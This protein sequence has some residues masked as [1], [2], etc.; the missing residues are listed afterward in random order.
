MLKVKT[1]ARWRYFRPRTRGRLSDITAYEPESIYAE[2]RL[3]AQEFY[4]RARPRIGRTRNV[5]RTTGEAV[6]ML[7]AHQPSDPKHLLAL[8]IL[9]SPNAA[10]AQ[11]DLDEHHGGYRNREA[12]VFEL[13]DFNDTFVSTVLALSPE[14]RRDF[15]G[16]AKDELDYFCEQ[17]HIKN[18]SDQQYEAIWHG[19]SREIAVFLAAKEIG[20]IVHMSSRVQDSMGIDMTITDAEAKRAINIDVKTHSAYHF[21]LLELYEQQRISEEKRLQCELSG[22][23]ESKNGHGDQAVTTVLFRI[24]TDRLGEID[25]FAFKDIGPVA[26]LIAAAIHDY[27]HNI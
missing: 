1:K 7:R 10:R 20:Y 16:R 5:Y 8:L 14:E 2:A 22:Y 25:N 21:R 9:Q 13:I 3:I 11:H 27:G 18:F 17:L 26:S 15:T 19:L 4:H 12:R 24:A 23:C 6:R